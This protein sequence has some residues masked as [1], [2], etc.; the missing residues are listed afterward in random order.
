MNSRFRT[1]LIFLSEMT[2]K[3]EQTN[4]KAAQN[5]TSR[6][7]L[8]N[9]SFSFICAIQFPVGHCFKQKLVAAHRKS[10]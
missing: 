2:A 4:F 6:G 1:T 9:I 10:T 5:V 3:L 7:T 8:P